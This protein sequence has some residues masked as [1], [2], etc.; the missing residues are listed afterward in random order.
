MSGVPY[1]GE[2]P[3]TEEQSLGR[4]KAGAPLGAGNVGDGSDGAS[5]PGS[6][7]T[8]RRGA[9]GAPWPTLVVH[10]LYLTPGRRQ[11]LAE[12]GVSPEPSVTLPPS[13]RDRPGC[14]EKRGRSPRAQPDGQGQSCPGD[15]QMQFRLGLRKKTGVDLP[16]VKG[17]HCLPRASKPWGSEQGL[18]PLQRHP[19]RMESPVSLCLTIGELSLPP[20]VRGQTGGG[21][22]P[23]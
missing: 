15:Q 3:H 14:R 23:A 10:T 18:R 20:G 13:S 2:R 21:G 16:S 4:E 9:P 5:P 19:G 8:H 17:P 6:N 11:D 1:G 22:T 7:R 12:A